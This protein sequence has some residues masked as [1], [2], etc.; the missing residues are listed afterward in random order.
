MTAR[1]QTIAWTAALT[2]VAAALYLLSSVLLPFIAAFALGYLLDPVADRL[3]RIGLSRLAATLLI[4]L[5]FAFLAVI[6]VGLAAP[7]LTRQF[8]S[9]VG[10]FPDLVAKAQDILSSKSESWLRALE[11]NLS[12]LLG[13]DAASAV[14][15]QKVAPD[16]MR[17]ASQWLLGVMKSVLSGGAAIL[18]LASLLVI[19]PVVA[20]YVLL[21]WD[22]MIARIDA[23]IPPR[24]RSMVRQI[25]IEIDAAMAGFLR[26]QS[27]LCLF[28]G[29]W[30]GVGLTVI[31][32]NYGFLIGVI[33]GVLSFIPYVGSLTVLVLSMIVA[34]AQTWP[35]LSLPGL[36][37]LVFATGQFL[38]GNILSP[39]LVGESVGLHPVW[40]MFALMAFG[41]LFGFIGLLV[42][43]PVAAAL[44]VV[45]RHA[46]AAYRES[47]FFTTDAPPEDLTGA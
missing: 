41:A 22:R 37:L 5:V 38:E 4:M 12:G 9:F 6:L 15:A 44:G 27:L 20:F 14:D 33:G 47:A 13:P 43:V 17:A 42:A 36:A 3:E 11:I 34:V 16:V 10:A 25:A 2:G 18:N 35:S 30:Y 23:N 40:V 28:L 8:A 46:L 24:D 26:G 19:M 1:Q 29:I 45:V 32:V 7:I 39:R 21:D 31:G